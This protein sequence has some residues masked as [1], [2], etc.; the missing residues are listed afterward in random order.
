M[1]DPMA[2]GDEAKRS[3][4]ESDGFLKSAAKSLVE[5]VLRGGKFLG[6]GILGFLVLI[7]VIMLFVY[8]RLGIVATYAAATALIVLMGWSAYSTDQDAFQAEGYYAVHVDIVDVVAIFVIWFAVIASTAV[9]DVEVGDGGF[10]AIALGVTWFRRV[11]FPS[12]VLRYQSKNALLRTTAVLC[13]V[14]SIVT[15][16]F[17]IA[18]AA[19]DAPAYYARVFYLIAGLLVIVAVWI[20]RVESGHLAE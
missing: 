20:H 11:F 12:T 3:P 19:I 14:H 13:I 9:Y 6:L 8:F 5:D 2:E 17:G 4:R 16:L 7:G 18:A 15:A 1:S 10:L